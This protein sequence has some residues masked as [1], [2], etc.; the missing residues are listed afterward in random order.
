MLVRKIPLTIRLQQLVWIQDIKETT[1]Q[2]I[3]Q[4]REMND[5]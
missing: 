5:R 3:G 1:N 4:Q 2:P